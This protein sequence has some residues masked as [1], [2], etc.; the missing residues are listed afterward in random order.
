W[1]NQAPLETDRQYLVKHTTQTTPATVP[2]IRHKVDINTLENRD[3]AELQ[4]NEIGVVLVETHKPLFFDPYQRNRATG[5]FIFIDPITNETVG[6]GMIIGPEEQKAQRRVLEGVQFELSRVTAAERF[7][8]AGH[9]PA[10]VWLSGPADVA[11]AVERK[12]FD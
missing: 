8:R 9:R 6:A 5:G 7:S 4:M 12:L 10:T 3:A 11:Y 1:M 2:A